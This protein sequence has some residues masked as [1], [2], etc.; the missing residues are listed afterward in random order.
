MDEISVGIVEQKEFTFAEGPDLF[1]LDSGRT[2]SN[3]KIVYETYGRLNSEKS[4][5][6]LVA[7]AFSGNAHAA[8]YHSEH[9]K[10]SGWWDMMIG[11]GKALDTD[12]YFIICS[13]VLGGCAGSTGPSS[14]NPETGK[15]YALERIWLTHRK[16]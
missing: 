14:V 2:L 1:V 10:H 13:N 7:H 16:G 9:D 6:I 4:N 3:V 8:G 11:P 15:Q 12:K 5:A